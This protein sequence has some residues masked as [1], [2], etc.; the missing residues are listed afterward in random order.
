MRERVK[1][2]LIF[3][4][5][6][7]SRLGSLAF[8]LLFFL[9]FSGEGGLMQLN[10]LVSAEI[11]LLICIPLLFSAGLIISFFRE[12]L[13]GL[14]MVLSIVVFNGISLMWMGFS[15]WNPDFLYLLVPG[16]I[17]MALGC[18]QMRR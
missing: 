9:M 5:R 2:I 17:F 1:R 13:G 11:L 15:Q 14:V 10:Q 16:I 12:F 3:K 18:R 6:W 7:V 8:I 4:L